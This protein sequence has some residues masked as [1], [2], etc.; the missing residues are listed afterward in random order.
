[1]GHLWKVPYKVSPFCPYLTVNMATI[2]DSCFLLAD[3]LK[4]LLVLNC[5]VK[6]INIC[7]FC[8]IWQILFFIWFWFLHVSVTV[9]ELHMV[10]VVKNLILNNVENLI[11]M[12]FYLNDSSW[13]IL[14]IYFVAFGFCIKWVKGLIK[15]FCRWEI[16][17]FQL[18][19]MF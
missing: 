8:R 15:W 16:F 4:Y 3:L 18:I 14:E 19:L 6:L 10:R 5:L 7:Q 13:K 2:D 12:E 9:Y 1:M 11:L 17:I